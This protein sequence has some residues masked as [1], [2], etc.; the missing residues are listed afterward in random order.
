MQQ[1]LKSMTGGAGGASPFGGPG[2]SPFGGPGGNPFAGMPMSPPGSQFPFPMP[3]PAA[4]PSPV[5]AAAAA[6]PV[7]VA[8]TSVTSSQPSVKS[9]PSTSPVETRKSGK[10]RRLWPSCEFA[11]IFLELCSFCLSLN[12]CSYIHS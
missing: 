11:N 2:G 4:S 8:P 3:P 6:P 7:D 12:H 5:S 10:R 9:E 1:M